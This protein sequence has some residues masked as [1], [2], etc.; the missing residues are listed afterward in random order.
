MHLRLYRSL[1]PRL[2]LRMRGKQG[3]ERPEACD[4]TPLVALL[5]AQPA[6]E[7]ESDSESSDESSEE[8]ATA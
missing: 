8:S 6:V 7:E 3:G 2:C 4:A 5:R 1:S